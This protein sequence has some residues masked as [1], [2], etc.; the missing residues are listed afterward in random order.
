MLSH[1]QEYEVATRAARGDEEA[2]Q[3]LVRSNL[4]FVVSVAKQYEQVSSVLTLQDLINEGAIGLM[5]AA[6]RFDPTR[7]FKF[8]SYGVFWIR[9]SILIAISDTGRTIRLPHNR[10]MVGNRVYHAMGKLEQILGRKPTEDELAAF[11]N[12]EPY[13]LLMVSKTETISLETPMGEDG[14]PLALI[15]EA[16]QEPSEIDADI[17]I[18]QLEKAIAKLPDSHAEVVRNFYGINTTPKNL[19][20]IGKRNNLSKERIRQVKLVGLKQ[21]AKMLK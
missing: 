17:T 6:E 21:L 11:M 5:R 1:E 9:Q 14:F 18:E 16:E 20:T 4:R 12:I 10:A 8:I 2:R 7:G 3:T 19:S 13:E 15:L